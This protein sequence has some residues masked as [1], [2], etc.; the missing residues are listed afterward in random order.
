M[1]DPN[2]LPSTLVQSTATIVAIIA[3][4]LVSRVLSLAT[5]KNSLGNIIDDLTTEYD[6]KIKRLN[7]LQDSFDES[8]QPEEPSENT[9]YLRSMLPIERESAKVKAA[10]INQQQNE[11]NYL[12]VE[13]NV[14]E[15]KIRDLSNKLESIKQPKGLSWGILALLYFSMVGIIIPL[16]FLPI[17][18]QAFTAWH[19]WIF[20]SLFITGLI[21]VF[22]YLFYSIRNL[23]K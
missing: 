11:Y 22:S 20:F 19:K 1:P 21:T 18:S 6:A 23:S 7:K 9:G 12:D 8:E 2:W 4:F 14:I 15:N 3:G 5:E 10:K 17:S 13:C 16:S